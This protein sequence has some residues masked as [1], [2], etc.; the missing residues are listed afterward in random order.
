MSVAQ[1]HGAN[2]GAMAVDVA[3]SRAPYH[4][5]YIWTSWLV[6]AIIYVVFTITYFMVGGTDVNGDVRARSEGAAV[7]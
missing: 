2:F 7:S 3:L 6:Y 1:V 4:F 5:I